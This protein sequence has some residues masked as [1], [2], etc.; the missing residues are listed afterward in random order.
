M[1]NNKSKVLL[2][3]TKYSV[4]YIPRSLD[5]KFGIHTKN[6]KDE[7]RAEKPEV[8]KEEKKEEK[9]VEEYED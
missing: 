2:D 3:N 9:K 6:R 7:K 1:C 4:S 8:K 5:E